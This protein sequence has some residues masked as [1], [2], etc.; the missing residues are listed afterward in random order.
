M[1]V[2]VISGFVAFTINPGSLGDIMRICGVI[3]LF[4]LFIGNYRIGEV[5]MGHLA[6]LGIFLI[7]LLING[8]VP[9]EMIH[10]RSYRYFLALPGMILAV[11]C[12]SKISKP[13]SKTLLVYCSIVMLAVVVHFIAFHTV[14]RVMVRG[15]LETFSLYSNMHHF[16]SFAS[17]ILPVL[18][19]FAIQ[20]KGLL[21]LL[22]GVCMVGAFYLLW[23]STSRISWL[24]FFGSVLLAAF[25][26]LRNKKLWLSLAGITA[27]SFMAAAVS[28]FA[29]IKN[30]ISDILINWRTEER[31]FVWSDTLRMLGDNSFK[32]W[33][34]G[35]G[36]G[37]FRYYIPG[38]STLEVKGKIIN[39]NFPH[40]FFLQIV[41][42]NGVIGLL[43]IS[44]GVA[45][46]QIG[47]WRGY[48]RLKS[49]GDRYLLATIFILFW[50]NFI[51]GALTLSFYH[52]YFIYPL[53]MIIGISLILLEKTGQ[54]RPL[55][56]LTW[57]QSLSDYL[58]K[59]LP[60]LNR[61][62]EFRN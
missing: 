33:M 2:A 13:G 61:R 22:C 53:S 57:Y 30:S 38:Y 4:H 48:R 10:S 46:L 1:E 25:V 20:N 11:H 62:R 31:L 28:G 40:N 54:N 47:L 43:T 12:L 27:V 8:L 36:I 49:I 7:T 45:L 35:H 32:D 42:E 5:T 39:W 23:E 34:L 19:Y 9:D 14:E 60:V 44:A 56:S 37:S 6:V 16:G 59:K 18:F 26:L 55:E 58:M 41:F 3:F 24:S 17:L 21:R 52:K 51:H 15:G 29:A 50:I